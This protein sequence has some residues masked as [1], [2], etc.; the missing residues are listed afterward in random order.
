M[1]EVG[2]LP[3][4]NRI[5]KTRYKNYDLLA[6]FWNGRYRGRIWKN[7]VKI[8]DHNGESIDLIVDSL[9][10]T[11]DQL[12]H[13]QFDERN[14]SQLME[15]DYVNAWRTVMGKID[16]GITTV[17][18]I[19]ARSRNHS[20]PV[21]KLTKLAGFDNDSLLIEGIKAIESALNDE[22]LLEFYGDRAKRE[23]LC[24]LSTYPVSIPEGEQRLT[25]ST[26]W[27][28]ALLQCDFEQAPRSA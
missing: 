19:L 12:R 9:L 26:I 10:Q 25:M 23:P 8:A 24:S 7:G 27:A 22:L 6:R 11:I 13:R 1:N 17:L 28:D 2:E 20:A 21:S 4:D 14:E 3:I 16:E 15:V 5:V 18:K